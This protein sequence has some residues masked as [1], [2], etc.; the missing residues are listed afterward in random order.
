MTCFRFCL[1]LAVVVILHGAVPAQNLEFDIPVT[2]DESAVL[3]ESTGLLN[4]SGVPEADVLERDDR[5]SG[6][7]TGQPTRSLP[8]AKW[9]W[10]IVPGLVAWACW[11]QSRRDE[12]AAEVETISLHN[13]ELQKKAD[14][15]A[16]L[17]LQLEEARSNRDDRLA[18]FQVI[19]QQL[20]A[21]INDAESDNIALKG[22]NE[23]LRKSLE[24]AQA[25]TA[26]ETTK[27][28]ALVSDAIQRQQQAETELAA[29]QTTV[30]SLRVEKV[31]LQESL[32]NERAA[33]ASLAAENERLTDRQLSEVNAL[34]QQI[35]QLENR[36]AEQGGLLE[37]QAGEQKD[38]LRIQVENADRVTAELNGRLRRA[39]SDIDQLNRELEESRKEV[40]KA[41]LAATQANE[42]L[43]NSSQ[44][45]ADGIRARSRATAAQRPKPKPKP[46]VASAMRRKSRSAAKPTPRDDLKQIR[47]IGPKSAAMLNAAGI[48]TFRDLAKAKPSKLRSILEQAGP[49]LRRLDSAKWPALAAR[50]IKKSS[51]RS[52]R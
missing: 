25:T 43:H 45:A 47:G 36:V 27:A 48:R 17:S 19:E 3:P 6:D 50:I 21:R 51:R 1:W 9:L 5:E 35:G 26:A 15:T 38:R 41:N 40:A 46:I 44:V 22:E 8:S 18:E 29:A 37:R 2:E 32:D 7:L 10:L 24:A 12:A 14:A 13:A 16:D 49:N 34:Q 11:S 4:S 39:Q 20:R 23:R 42:R 28:D 33:N 31:A 30:D 52:G